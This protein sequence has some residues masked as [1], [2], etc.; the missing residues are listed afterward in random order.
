[1]LMGIHG[2]RLESGLNCQSA[3]LKIFQHVHGI[4]CSVQTHA[5]HNMYDAA[6]EL[7]APLEWCAH[8][9]SI[10]GSQFNFGCCVDIYWQWALLLTAL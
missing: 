1:M 8:L 7:L 4:R 6:F 2:G 9:L 5:L 10:L 3:L